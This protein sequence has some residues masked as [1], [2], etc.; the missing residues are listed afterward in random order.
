MRILAIGSSPELQAA[1][2]GEH[3]EMDI[4]FQ[5]F[6]EAARIEQYLEKFSDT[7]AL[8]L[9]PNIEKP[10]AL[11]QEVHR[12]NS[13]L[14]QVIAADDEHAH[15]YKT[16]L[17]ITPHLGQS[18]RCI[19]IK[20]KS[21]L[22]DVCKI[23]ATKGE[24]MRDFATIAADTAQ[25]LQQNQVPYT[26][27][28]AQKRFNYLLNLAPIGII[29]LDAKQ[30]VKEINPMG[31][32]ILNTTGYEAI[33]NS[34]A[35]FTSSQ[36]TTV[37]DNTEV[38]K[39]SD[40][41]APRPHQHLITFT[42]SG[43][44]LHYLEVTVEKFIGDNNEVSYLLL[45]QDITA[46]K[47]NEID[48]VNMEASTR[49]AEQA[50]NAKSEF[51]TRVSHELRTPLNA[52]IGFSNILKSRLKEEDVG[53]LAELPD[54][55]N[56]A[57]VALLDMI[58]NILDVTKMEQGNLSL[59]RHAC[60][61]NDVISHCLNKCRSA[62]LN[63]TISINYEGTNCLVFA[64]T[65]RLE[66]IID[67]LLSNAIKY[68]SPGGQVGIAVNSTD[69]KVINIAI[70]DTGIGIAEENLMELFQPFSRLNIEKTTTIKGTGIGLT[71]TK[72]LIDL[73]GG[74]LQVQ[75]EVGKGSC[76]TVS[77]PKLII[78][79]DTTRNAH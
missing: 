57:G 50:N 36:I 20:D 31:L 58:N 32:M 12:N 47:V 51:L 78:Q 73:M 70:K 19:S 68:N 65:E 49:A 7:S 38:R 61:V 40:Q 37:I 1:F 6:C 69:N 3:C 64:D 21:K 48:L 8:I 29:Q 41:Q 74:K 9:G 45:I 28:Q 25:L 4:D 52:I 62:Q 33:G 77:L 23:A 59:K 18:T 5:S 15:S 2:H 27:N 60:S 71:L 10:L 11:A 35:S 63:Q 67:N 26:T 14:A 46:R 66:Q 39:Q 30:L 72:Q 22:R 17:L 79:D 13:N 34:I 43:T 75:S 54:H 16:A 55:I 44:D 53:K 24:R 42:R 56:K 76:F